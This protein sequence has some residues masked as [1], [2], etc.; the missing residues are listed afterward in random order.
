MSKVSL[1]EKFD[2]LK[3]KFIEDFENKK[4]WFKMEVFQPNTNVSESIVSL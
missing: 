4:D 2:T 3:M 1:K